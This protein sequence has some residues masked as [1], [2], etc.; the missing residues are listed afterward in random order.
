M[1]NP[2]TINNQESLKHAWHCGIGFL[3]CLA[4]KVLR[5][6]FHR[7]FDCSPLKNKMDNSILIYKYVWVNPSEGKGLTIYLLKMPLST[8]ANIADP[9]QADLV[10]GRPTLFAYGNIMRYYP[11]LV[12]L[13]SNFFDLQ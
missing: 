7:N 9:D 3:R 1:L 10:Q 2:Y 13:T 8:F 6:R 12:N 5:E 4:A 11:T